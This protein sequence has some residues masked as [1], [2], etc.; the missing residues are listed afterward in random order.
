M[1]NS[2]QRNNSQNLAEYLRSFPL[3]EGENKTAV[4]YFNIYRYTYIY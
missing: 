4:P 3:K 1:K 2:S